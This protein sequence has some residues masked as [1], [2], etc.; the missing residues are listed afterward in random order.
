MKTGHYVIAGIIAAMILT[1]ACA[2]VGSPP[3][4]SKDTTPPKV[5]ESKPAN[6]SVNF[7]GSSIEIRFDE[8]I[9][10]DNVQ[11][12]LIVSP[13]L[14]KRPD[15]QIK[16]KALVIHL[17]DT[18]LKNTTYT[19]NFGEAIKDVDEGNILKNYSFV[20]STG[21]ALDSLQ[22]HGQLVNA[23]T[24]HPPKEA[25]A[26][27]Y[28]DLNDSAPMLQKP[29][30]VSK[31]DKNGRFSLHNLKADTFRIVALVDGN[32]NY[33]YDPGQD[34][35]GFLDTLLYIYPGKNFLPVCDTIKSDSLTR[36]P[37]S[38]LL[39]RLFT[40]DKQQQYLKNTDRPLRE[41]IQ[42]IFNLPAP[43]PD[44]TLLESDTTASWY[45]P[46]KYITNDTL[47]LWLT[48]PSL[49]HKDR[50][51]LAVTYEAKD[52]MGNPLH[53]TDTVT[54]RVKSNTAVRKSKKSKKIKT[55]EKP[56]LTL[57]ISAS[58]RKQELNRALVIKTSMPVEKADT[59]K[60]RFYRYKDTIKV[61]QPFLPK[62]DTFSLR[63]FILQCLWHEN[64]RYELELLPGAFTDIYGHGH[65]TLTTSFRTRK[66]EEYGNLKFNLTDISG[67]TLIQLW[68]T[69]E[70]ARI[71]QFIIKADTSVHFDYLKPGKYIIKAVADRNHNGK[72]DTG[73]YL[74]K[75]PPEPVA[76]FS[77]VLNIKANWAVEETWDI[78]YDF[79]PRLSSKK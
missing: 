59:S 57:S 31:A 1:G 4:G 66:M 36:E 2:R 18:L 41:Y 44:I 6:H 27:L 32:L 14:Q 25:F 51:D 50:F 67:T 62:K 54:L 61:R 56:A 15:V 40:E 11:K 30:Y 45:I 9:Q 68:N 33:M 38:D 53:V 74:E 55:K 19:F 3:G 65:D 20:F 17:H 47:G 29:L 23:F 5:M 52:S 24:L 58:G 37:G 75:Y 22:I 63:T 48:E 16:G 12:K 46:E 35:I 8:F 77:K 42:I 73:N 76:Y 21:P 39:L 64:T 34:M 43:H 13:P 79:K 28:E 70:D 10:L 69:R 60:I 49:I 72:W 26:M 7:T 71:R 78:Q